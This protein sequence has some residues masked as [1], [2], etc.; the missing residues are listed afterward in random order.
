MVVLL[1]V[2]IRLPIK[3]KLTACFLSL[4]VLACNTDSQTGA[5]ALSARFEIEASDIARVEWAVGGGGLVDPISGLAEVLGGVNPTVAVT[6]MDLP[7]GTGYGI[8]LIAYDAAD[9]SICRGSAP[10]DIFEG[11]TTNIALVMTC[12]SSSSL[13]SGSFGVDVTFQDNI[14]PVI[15]QINIVPQTIAVGQTAQVSVIALDP[16]GATLAYTWSSL[17]GTFA[18]AS[19]G[20]TTYQCTEAIDHNISINVSDGDTFCDQSRQLNV[21]C[22]ADIC[23]GPPVLSCD[24]GNQCTDDGV[25]DPISGCPGSTPSLSGAACDFASVGDGLCDGA[26]AC[27]EC[28]A[29][30]DCTDDGNEC[31]APATCGAGTCVVTNEPASV[32]C[33]GGVCDGGGA[34]TGCAV[35]GDCAD[36]SNECTA[37]VTCNAG[38]CVIANEAASTPCTG[39]VCNGAGLCVECVGAGDCTDDG[40]ECTTGPSCTAGACDT[41][42]NL[43]SGTLCT[44]GVCNGAGACVGCVTAGDCPDDANECTSAPSCT[45]N[46]CDAQTPLPNTTPCDNGGG[47][48]SGLC[49]GAGACL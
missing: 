44:G 22:V 30:T 23:V 5:A 12:S 28:L 40:N 3:L 26:G 37:P 1:L 16:E 34:C 6:I 7:V 25:C 41:P 45:A 24:D 19:L 4:A 11:V 13:P 35:D 38:T 49:D 8:T 36:D 33:T 39:G 48:A 29:G 32:P 46:A 21:T 2:M 14:C 17:A 31:T 18:D 20:T 27:V 47:P 42:A 10:F 9:T 15:N 43:A